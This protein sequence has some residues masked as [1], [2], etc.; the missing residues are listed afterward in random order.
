VITGA[1]R[2]FCAGGDVQHMVALRERGESFDAL[3]PLLDAGRAVI[4]R[5]VALPFPTV[6]AVNGPAAGAG[7]NLAL[8]CDLRVASDQATFGE[9]FARIG[10]HLDWGGSWF[11]PRLVGSSRAMELCWLGDPI[12]A[13]E[14]LRVGLVNRVWPQAEFER[15]W[16]ELAARLAAAPATSVRLAKQNLRASPGR[17]LEECLD[18]ETAAQAACWAS[19]DS[20]E[21]LRAFV[22][23]RPPAFG[24]SVAEAGTRSGRFE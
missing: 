16:R 21:G 11:L 19:A 15:S 2:A 9:T 6:A 13:G 7:M 20:A 4:E 5:L 1:G 24:A 10:L 12:G 17:S 8:A 3:R 22:E 23:K 18:A 14:A